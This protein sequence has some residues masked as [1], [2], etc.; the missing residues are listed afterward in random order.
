[1]H[2]CVRLPKRKEAYNKKT[3]VTDS[4]RSV[5]E[6]SQA[7]NLAAC[8]SDSLFYQALL[9]T[10]VKA[11]WWGYMMGRNRYDGAQPNTHRMREREEEHVNS[12]FTALLYS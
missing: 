5:L 2:D 8:P 7:R 6:Y 12:K 10:H 3:C 9:S 1:V 11:L 4:D